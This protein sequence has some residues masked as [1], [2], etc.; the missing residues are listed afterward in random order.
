M[1][2]NSSGSTFEDM[3]KRIYEGGPKKLDP[4]PPEIEA[5]TDR[6]VR[7]KLEVLS[8]QEGDGDCI[9]QY[10]SVTKSKEESYPV[11]LCIELALESAIL[12]WPALH[13]AGI[14]EQRTIFHRQIR[15]ADDAIAP[16]ERQRVVT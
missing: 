3:L 2:D 11:Q 8:E 16:E 12:W 9:A 5:A 7:R 10:S 13:V 14:G 1:K 15:P 4:R 6:T